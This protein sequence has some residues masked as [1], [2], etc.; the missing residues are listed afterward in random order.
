MKALL[1]FLLILTSASEAFFPLRTDLTCVCGNGNGWRAFEPVNSTDPFLLIGSLQLSGHCVP[2]EATM[3]LKSD[4]RRRCVN[5]FLLGDA[6]LF[7]VEQGKP[8][9]IL[10]EGLKSEL[11]QF[12]HILKSHVS[13]RPP[14]L[15]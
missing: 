13:K 8:E 15:R 9:S 2:P 7:G 12:V 10:T 14:S 6:L 11:L 3:T 5:P 4:Q 1:F